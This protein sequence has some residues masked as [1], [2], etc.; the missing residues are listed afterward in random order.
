MAF[1][2]F[3]D[4]NNAYLFNVQDEATVL[5]CQ[6]QFDSVSLQTDDFFQKVE[7][8]IQSSEEILRLNSQISPRD[9]ISQVS[10][11]VTLKLS[12]RQS[13]HSSCSGSH[14]SGSSSLAIA[15]AKEVARIAELKA[16]AAAFKKH[17]SLEKQKFHL[18]Q[19]Q[20]RLMLET[21]IAKSEAKEKLLASVMEATPCSFV[22]IPSS[23][24]PGKSEKT[25]R[26]DVECRVKSR[27]ARRKWFF[28]ICRGPSVFK[29]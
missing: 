21:E 18:Q 1:R 3:Q 7:R 28:A 15:R 14:K 8:W 12:T 13:R 5:K 2:A 26:F 20:D 22:P 16:E 4:A 19:E 17:Q 27:A 23:S 11:R 25:I 24:E 6:E 29:V 9:S 10:S